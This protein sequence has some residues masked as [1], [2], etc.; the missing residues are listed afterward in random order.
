MM[1]V[2]YFALTPD[3]YSTRLDNSSII[4]Q[5]ELKFENFVVNSQ[6]TRAISS[7]RGVSNIC[8]AELITVSR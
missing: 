6:S 8:I 5:C 4:F 1:Y 3:H 7:Q 2:K